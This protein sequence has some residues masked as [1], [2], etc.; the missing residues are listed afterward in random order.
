MRLYTRKEEVS[1]NRS[2]GLIR[3]LNKPIKLLVNLF[4]L[5]SGKKRIKD[6][7]IGAEK[8]PT[9]TKLEVSSFSKGLITEASPLTYPDNASLVDENNVL[10][11]DGSRQRRLGLTFES[12]NT[13]R[14]YTGDVV[15]GF[16]PM[17]STHL[18]KNPNKTGAYD[19]VVVQ[20]SNKLR[21]FKADKTSISTNE[22]NGGVASNLPA[23]YTVETKISVASLLGNLVV[24]YGAQNVLIYTYNESTQLV[25]YDIVNLKV[26]DL[27]GIDT[28]YAVNQ[29]VSGVTLPL[30]PAN[31]TL[32]NHVYNLRNQGFPS[33]VQTSETADGS[34]ATGAFDPILLERNANPG[35]NHILAPDTLVW[36][37]YKTSSASSIANIG[38]YSIFSVYKDLS[39]GTNLTYYTTPAPKGAAVLDL[40]N[41]S[42]SRQAFVD[43][44]LNANP[45]LLL[46]MDTSSGGVT[47][48]AT[49]AGR[50]FYTV[51]ETSLSG[52]DKNTP[53]LSNMILFS[54]TVKT[55]NEIN[56]CYSISDPTS[57]YDFSPLATD[58]GFIVIPDAG[59]ILK[60]APLGASLFVFATNGVWEIFGGEGG[61]SALNVN[62]V[63]TSTIGAL[64]A[65]A[66]VSSESILTYWAAGGIHLINIDPVNNRGASVNISI[67]TIQSLFL[68]IPDSEKI[69]VT[70][71]FDEVGRKLRWLY[72]ET[73]T[74]WPPIFKNELIFDADLR[75]FY[76]NRIPPTPPTG[77]G[78]IGAVALP[79]IR[80]L[81]GY[82]VAPSNAVNYSFGSYK[83][84]TFYDFSSY[85]PPALLVTGYLTG[86][87]GSLSK[88]VKS[89]ETHLKRTETGFHD[90]GS[91]NIVFTNPSG[92]VV[93]P[94]W[95]WTNSAA[96]GKWGKPM[97]MYR[98]QRPY[99]PS[100]VSDPFDY[101]YTVITSKTSLRGRGRALS[102]KFQSE[103]GKDM[104]ILGWGLEVE[105][106]SEF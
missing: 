34:G 25:S 67:S 54:Q 78:I 17:I 38:N 84:T 11:K 27:F 76:T 26:R 23:D 20:T 4:L 71:V 31:Q 48:V 10:N 77:F 36:W 5:L 56:K 19:I 12:P 1:Q 35:P 64:S 94:Q 47:Q 24:T 43:S 22:L 15:G 33:V 7:F 60:L 55:T 42:V 59:T 16:Q 90:D 86:Q 97:Q 8:V 37:R 32:I 88:Q 52:G 49:F 46:P 39:P 75:A 50:Y 105:V 18:W 79:E 3:A 2:Q 106:E 9:K 57:E 102:L 63:K 101:S 100:G 92:C 99:Y 87:A 6:P 45:L 68:A 85:D 28:P 93:T 66:V 65:N 72:N 51:K 30:V 13:L 41:R 98:L 81:I 103:P 40:F 21:F 83:D 74:I 14:N 61:F 95:E 104:R 73:V 69:K 58:G 29:A 44:L 80:Y 70:G 91:G 62:V 89:L 82:N 96:A 53:K